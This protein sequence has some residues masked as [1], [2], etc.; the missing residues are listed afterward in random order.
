MGFA[1]AKQT[2][3]GVS[4]MNTRPFDPAE[5]VQRIMRERKWNNTQLAANLGVTKG[6]I[7]QWLNGDFPNDENLAKLAEYVEFD[8][9][10]AR[11]SREISNLRARMRRMGI[12][13]TKY[14]H[15][16]A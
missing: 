11:A 8:I 9:E 15:L 2:R 4:R 14:V 10:G 12:D 13:F 16:V 1:F 3:R 7:S 5:V 6:L